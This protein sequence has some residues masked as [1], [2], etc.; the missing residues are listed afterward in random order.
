MWMQAKGVDKT[1]RMFTG[2]EAISVVATNA[3]GHEVAIPVG[4]DTSGLRATAMLTPFVPGPLSVAINIGNEPIPVSPL[5]LHVEPGKVSARH[6]TVIP[7]T[8]DYAAESTQVP[9]LM[10]RPVL[11]NSFFH[12]F[13]VFWDTMHVVDEARRTGAYSH[14]CLD[15]VLCYVTLRDGLFDY[16]TCDSIGEAVVN[17]CRSFRRVR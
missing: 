8:K 14:R 1:R 2:G 6:C 16:V 12:V 15:A 9:S 3:I 7:V 13:E 11:F 4:L 10:S 5:V 17:W